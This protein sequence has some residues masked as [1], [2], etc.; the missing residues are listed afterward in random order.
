MKRNYKTHNAAVRISLLALSIIIC[1]AFNSC[2]KYLDAKP[3]KKLVV[4]STLQDCQ[5]I[6][7]NFNAMNVG[8]AYD[9]EASSDNYFLSNT[10]WASSAERDREIYIWQSDAIVNYGEW[11]SAYNRILY[12]NQALKTLDEMTDKDNANWNE[13]KGEALFFRGFNFFNLAQIFCQPYDA[14]SASINLGIPLRL[15]PSITDATI[16]GTLQETYDRILTDINEATRLLSPSNLPVTVINKSRAC[17]TAAYAF[18]SRVY[19]SMR[20]YTKAG[21]YADSS[22]QSYNALMNYNT[23]NAAAANPILRFNDE[24]IF[25]GECGFGISPYNGRV[26]TTLYQ[27]YASNDLRRTVFFQLNTDGTYSFKGGYSN[28]PAYTMFCGLAT[29]EIY[30]TRAECFARAGNKTAALKDL[31]DLLRSRWQGAYNDLTAVNANAALALILTE[32]RKELLFR[33]HLRWMDLRRLNKE[34]A[35]A[36]TLTHFLNN[37]TYTLPPNDL[38]YTLLIPQEVMSRT[39]MQQNPR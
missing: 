35:F 28:A 12:A 11:S 33:G 6:I 2:K 30:L 29:D 5:A 10:A 15:T 9:G 18:L 20:D 27:S 37:Q 14:A 3:D 22:L 34:P 7:D 21:A 8:Y 19:L 23:L 16:R 25:Q 4:P 13:V 31:N 39:D 26:D 32:R 1:F 38:R 24:V 17:K 36:V